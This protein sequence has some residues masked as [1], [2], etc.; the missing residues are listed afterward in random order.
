[1]E[2]IEM[3]SSFR[4]KYMG[5]SNFSDHPVTYRGIVYSSSE[6][7]FQAQK[8]LD[9]NERRRIAGMAPGKAK[10]YCGRRGTVRLREDWEAVKFSLMREIVEEKF[11]Q[12]PQLKALLLSTGHAY[13]KEGNNWHDD[14]W[15]D[16]TCPQH[17][18]TPGK[19]NLG[20]I[21]M[22]IREMFRREAGNERNQ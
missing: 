19:N 6:T 22:D 4:D 5:F 21:I 13:L 16:C 17:K 2:S 1:M 10:F 7:A 18:H 15:G 20:I 8:T 14:E 3:I 9:E 12:H 11:Q